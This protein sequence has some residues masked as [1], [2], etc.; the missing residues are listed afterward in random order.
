MSRSTR[1]AR[2]V[3]GLIGKALRPHGGQLQPE[4]GS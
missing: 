2:E 4:T 3:A 1:R